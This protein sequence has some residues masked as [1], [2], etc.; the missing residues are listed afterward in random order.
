MVLVK[1]HKSNGISDL[2]ETELIPKG[3]VITRAML[4]NIKYEDVNP[5]KWTSDKTANEQIKTLINNYLIAYKEYDATLK[6]IKYNL[7]IGDELPSGIMQ[8]APA[9]C[10]W[11]RSTWP[12]RGRSAS[13][14][15]WPDATETRVS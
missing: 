9:S 11:P 7:T 15:R 13:A 14:T 6:R 4:E 3:T 12:R 2:Y 1:D 8:L 10:S 5:A